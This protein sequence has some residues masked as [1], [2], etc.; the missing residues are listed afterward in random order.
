MSQPNHGEGRIVRVSASGVPGRRGDTTE[1]QVWAVEGRRAGL[2]SDQLATEEPLEIRLLTEEPGL[3]RLARRGSVPAPTAC[4]T[5]AITMRTPGDDL[6]LAA[7]FL[8]GEGIVREREDV[9]RVSYCHDETLETEWRDN[10]VNVELRAGL[11][12]DLKS[13]ERHFYTTSACGVC[14]KTSLDSLRLRG[15]AAVPP[16]PV[17][18]AAILCDLPKKLQAAQAIFGATGGLHAAALFDAEGELLA[19]REDV[20]RHNALDKLVGWAFM[21]GRL[22]WHG[23][24]VM[25]SGRSSFEILQKCVAAGAPIVCAVS[26]P[27]SLAVALALEFHITLTG[28]LRGQRFNVYAGAERIELG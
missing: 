5:V 9:R 17:I 2:R 7:G 6:A 24:V 27:S 25:V 20:G 3:I 22:P 26:A 28:F 21:E 10:V 11:R 18:A 4:R 1:A 8:Y 12:P 15:Y 19:L 23:H 13:L 16:G 14:G